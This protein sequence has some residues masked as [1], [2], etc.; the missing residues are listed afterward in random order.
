MKEKEKQGYVMYK[1]W[2]PII[3][4]IPDE[5]AG[6]LFK[7]VATFQDGEAVELSDPLLYGIFQMMEKT[8]KIDA[9]KY[10]E[11][12]ERRREAGRK[13]G[14]PPANKDD[15]Q[16]RDGNQKK[17]KETKRFINEAKKPDIDSDIDSDIEIEK[18][19][20]ID[21]GKEVDKGCRGEEEKREKEEPHYHGDY[22]N[23]VLTDSEWSA[24]ITQFGMDTV[25]N[26][27]NHLSYLMNRNRETTRKGHYQRL[28]DYLASE[29]NE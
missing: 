24:L 6:K 1:S 19:V 3:R 25:D 26:A 9:E 16:G 11:I 27:I 29:H 12:C 22:Q 2:N 8:F 21:K 18:G 4:S 20:E 10:H 14:R 13:G 5:K 7:A 28:A 23:I 15:L 17:P